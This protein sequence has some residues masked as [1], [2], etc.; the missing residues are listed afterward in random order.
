[1]IKLIPMLQD[2]V[3]GF[4]AIG[5]VTAN[6]YETVLIPE[7]ELLLKERAK[8]RVF[9]Y[10]GPEFSG[11]SAGAL[12]DDLKMGLKHL[13]AWEKIAIVTDKEWIKS[14]AD[15][16]KHVIPCPIAVFDN[17]QYGQA[18]IWIAA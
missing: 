9:C 5:E 11:F 16:F 12:W 13:T 4:V 3:I 18:K 1:M 17:K 15:T 2:N 7:V 6:D 8:I 14:G 10:L